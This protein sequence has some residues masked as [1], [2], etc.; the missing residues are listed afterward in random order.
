MLHQPNGSLRVDCSFVS[1]STDRAI[2][3][4]NE[5]PNIHQPLRIKIRNF[6]VLAFMAVV[7]SLSRHLR[8][9]IKLIDLELK[10]LKLTCKANWPSEQR[11]RSVRAFLKDA[12]VGSSAISATN[13]TSESR[14]QLSL[15]CE[16]L[17]TS[18]YNH[19]ICLA[20]RKIIFAR[21]VQEW[22]LTTLS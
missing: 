13:A 1:S 6:L 15:A 8:K 21:G 10:D 9:D 11:K 22:L 19:K 7:S 20:P 2:L 3:Y 12:A 18:G 5:C 17:D 16:L 14:S 4:A